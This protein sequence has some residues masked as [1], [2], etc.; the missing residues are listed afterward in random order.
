MNLL[1][2][3][4]PDQNISGTLNWE[5]PPLK[6]ESLPGGGIRVFVPAQVDYFQDPA[7]LLKK[8]DAPYLWLTVTGDFVAR[9]HVRPTFTTT[10]DAGALM[11][12][13]DALHWA[14][15]CYESTD[16]GTTAAVSVVTNGVSD[17]ANGADLTAPDLWLQMVRAGDVFGL[18]YALDGT[19]WRMVRL[20]KL[21]M[22]STIKVGL[23]A[24]CPAGPGATID[25]LSFSV[26]S[27]TL[28][29]LR[30]GV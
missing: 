3:F 6:W 5:N 24:Q 8:D 22:P 25:F 13:A 23:V 20:F 17:D 15:L 19:S 18:Q 16:L 4:T 7:G 2:N 11:A 26:E 1:Q 27:R 12:R 29:N 14:K 21:P 9:A 30:G 28:K 10:W